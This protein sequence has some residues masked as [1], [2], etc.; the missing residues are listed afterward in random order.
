MNAFIKTGFKGERLMLKILMA[1]ALMALIWCNPGWSQTYPERTV[2]IVVGFG[3]GGPDTTARVLAA[4]LTSQ[5]KQTFFVE[6]RPGGE[7]Q[8]RRL[9]PAGRSEFVC[10]HPEHVQDAAV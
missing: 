6:N 4:Q 10:F 9:Y 3:P 7:S 5:T 1:V 2:R 8:A